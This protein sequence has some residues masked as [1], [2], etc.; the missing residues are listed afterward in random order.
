M[1]LLPIMDEAASGSGFTSINKLADSPSPQS[2]TP[3]TLISP[4]VASVPKLTVMLWVELLPVAP[5][6]K[7][8]RYDVASSIGFTKKF[9]LYAGKQKNASPIIV[10]TGAG[11][12]EHIV[13]DC[14]GAK[15][16]PAKV[17]SI[18]WTDQL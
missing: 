6:G 11:G 18:A 10:S 3:F 1:L 15:G 14:L 7:V 9:I 16:P 8:Q 4:D 17:L 12:E 5:G 2:F 13:K